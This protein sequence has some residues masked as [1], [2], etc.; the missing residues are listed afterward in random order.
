MS[1]PAVDSS[2]GTGPAGAPLAARGGA[3]AAAGNGGAGVVAVSAAYCRGTTM[4]TGIWMPWPDVPSVSEIAAKRWTPGT[5]L[6]WRWAAGVIPG[7]TS[8]AV[9]IASAP[10]VCHDATT[11]ARWTAS[12]AIAANAITANASTSANVG[13]TAVSAAVPPRARPTTITTPRRRPASR[14]S[15]RRTIGYARRTSRAT[16]IATST[17]AALVNRSTLPGGG[18]PCWRSRTRPPTAAQTRAMSKTH[19]RV[20]AGAV[21]PHGQRRR[22]Y[23]RRHDD[24]GSQPPSLPRGHPGGGHHRG[25]DS[26]RRGGQHRDGATGQGDR[27]DLPQRC[28]ARPH[29]GELGVAVLGDQ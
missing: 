14:A 17:G 12:R 5:P 8:G 6:I 23:E 10:A 2:T 27:A 26:G 7:P 19:R 16:G 24:Q 29:H 3:S 21:L 11:S 1:R 15:W 22:A 13:N 4:T 18:R 9:T 28:P 20:A 25:T